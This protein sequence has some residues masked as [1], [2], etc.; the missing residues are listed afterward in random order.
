MIKSKR[1]GEI[2]TGTIIQIALWVAFIV[3][4]FIAVR[5]ALKRWGS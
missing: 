5:V 2:S 4:A 1:K 3:L